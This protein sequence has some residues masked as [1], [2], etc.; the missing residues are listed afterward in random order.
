MFENPFRE[1]RKF[2]EAMVGGFEGQR[3]AQQRSVDVTR[4]AMENYLEII[5]QT[6]PGSEAGV[7]QIRSAMDEQFE[8]L[9]EAQQEAADLTEQ[10]L[11][12]YEELSEAY[13]D[14]LSEQ[15]NLM[16]EVHED[17][18]RETLAFVEDMQAQLEEFRE[19]ADEQ[20]REQIDQLSSQA[21]QL[22][23]QMLQE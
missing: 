14:S 3:D 9:E 20:M 6:V 8:A 21:E 18:H 17:V 1:I 12:E 19:E 4:R 22:R 11:E 2:T 15:L 7:E 13:L 23:E 5:E 10:G 16:L